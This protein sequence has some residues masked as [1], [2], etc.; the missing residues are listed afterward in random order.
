MRTIVR[1]SLS[2]ALAA[3]LLTSAGS[4]LAADEARVRVL[5]ASPDA[6]AVDVQL[7]GQPVEALTNVPFGAISDYLKVPAGEHQVTVYPTGTTTTAVIDA[8]VTVEAGMSYTIA[9][10]NPVASIAPE[11]IVDDPTMKSGSAMVRVVHLGPDAPAVDVAVDGSSPADA[12]V[13][14]L[15]FPNAT[16][17]LALDP[18]T[19]D[20]EV[21]LAGTSDVGLQL[22]PLMLDAGKAY[23][24]FAIGSAAG[25]PLGG[26]ELRVLVAIDAMALPDTSTAGPTETPVGNPAL[27]VVLAIAAI[28]GF[29]LLVRRQAAVRTR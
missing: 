3:A 7:D 28:A 15:A 22:D 26:N 18:G 13:K 23:S 24:A 10:T 9:A 6:P 27:G 17:Y 21:R 14:G 11:V 4:A 20:L 25:E 1:S 12:V 29:S 2:L 8:A 5:H 19:Y 16:G